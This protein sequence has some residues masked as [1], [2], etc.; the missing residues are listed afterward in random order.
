[1]A[2]K[3]Y[4]VETRRGE[5]WHRFFVDCAWPTRRAA[6]KYGKRSFSKN[7]LLNSTWRVSSSD[8]P[9]SLPDFVQELS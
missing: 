2:T 1:M 5:T 3:S 4:I 8:L 6:E 7:E 9:V